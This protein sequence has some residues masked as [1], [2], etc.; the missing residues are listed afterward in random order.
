METTSE[1]VDR[2]IGELARAL[3]S[4][5]FEQLP[6]KENYQTRISA[7]SFMSGRYRDYHDAIKSYLHTLI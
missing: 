4:Y 2:L 7:A 3:A 1:K 6:D 5:D